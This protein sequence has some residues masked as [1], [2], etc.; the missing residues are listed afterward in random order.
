MKGRWEERERKIEGRMTKEEG[1]DDRKGEERGFVCVCLGG[2]RR[3]FY[4]GRELE[5][6]DEGEGEAHR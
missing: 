5:E 4:W 6:E 3:G 2:G 1:K